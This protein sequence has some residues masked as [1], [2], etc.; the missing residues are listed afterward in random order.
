M[1]HTVCNLWHKVPFVPCSKTSRNFTLYKCQ[2]ICSHMHADDNFTVESPKG[3]LVGPLSFRSSAPGKSSS[4]QCRDIW[5]SLDRLAG[6]W[7]SGEV[8]YVFLLSNLIFST[9]QSNFFLFFIQCAKIRAW[10]SLS[11]YKQDPSNTFYRCL[12]V[13][14]SW[15]RVCAAP[16]DRALM[17]ENGCRCVCVCVCV[18]VYIY[19]C[20]LLYVDIQYPVPFACV[21]MLSVEKRVPDP[22]AVKL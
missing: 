19:V 17:C 22:G 1:Q 2:P 8:C 7:E 3:L 16:P 6:E 20:V 14:C 4:H 15:T 9:T 11:E 18:C 21:C 10:I 12:L 5:R 13:L